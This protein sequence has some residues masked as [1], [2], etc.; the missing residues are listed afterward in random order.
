MND[1][2]TWFLKIIELHI[3][4]MDY[5]FVNVFLWNVRVSR[6]LELSYIQIGEGL[7]CMYKYVTVMCFAIK[8]FGKKFPYG[9]TY[10][11]RVFFK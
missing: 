3:L 6:P 10:S 7:V 1:F 4:L 5:N 2:D 8:V 11:R 9:K